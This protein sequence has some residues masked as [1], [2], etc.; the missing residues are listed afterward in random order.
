M[1]RLGVPTTW[2][3]NQSN[4]SCTLGRLHAQ[5]PLLPQLDCKIR[6]RMLETVRPHGVNDVFILVVLC[7]NK[8]FGREVRLGFGR[9]TSPC[10][11]VLLSTT[12]I[13]YLRC[14]LLVCTGR[15]SGKANPRQSMLYYSPHPNQQYSSM[16]PEPSARIDECWRPAGD[17]PNPSG[18]VSKNSYFKS[19]APLPPLPPPLPPGPAGPDSPASAGR[20]RPGRTRGRGRGKGWAGPTLKIRVSG[21]L[22][23]AATCYSHDLRHFFGKLLQREVTDIFAYI[24]FYPM[25]PPSCETCLAVRGRNAGWHSSRV[26]QLL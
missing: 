10:L 20:I 21:P 11:L 8:Y 3:A 19:R 17:V 5:L 23:V 12:R 26:L 16:L 9:V 25:P 24:S 13:A 7:M 18:Y 4:L 22:G 2:N 14:V 1:H 15:F 6:D